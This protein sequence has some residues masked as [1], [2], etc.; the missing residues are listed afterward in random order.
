MSDEYGIPPRKPRSSRPAPR[1][2]RYD[3]GT[4]EYSFDFDFDPPPRPRPPRRRRRRRSN[5]RPLLLLLLVLVAVGAIVLGAK[6]LAGGDGGQPTAAANSSTQVVAAEP[7]ASTAAAKKSK[8]QNQPVGIPKVT[9]APMVTALPPPSYAPGATSGRNQPGLGAI[10]WV[11]LDV[12]KNEILLAHNETDKRPIASLTK[13]MTGLLTSE[14]GN[15][16]HPVTVSETAADVEPNKDGLIIGNRYP[17]GILLYSAMLGSN[18]DA[19]AALGEDLGGGNYQRYYRMM[20]KRA[21]ELGMVHTHYAS[22]SG[23]NDAANW[24]TAR[25]QA[26]LLAR[27]LGNPTF[28]Q[29]IGTWRHVVRWPDTGKR[30]TYENH[31]DMLRTYPGTIGGKTGFT[32]LAGGCL[33][34]AV[35]RN[36]RTIIGVVLH[37]QDIWADMPVL[38]DAAFKRAG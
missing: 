4:D 34:V 27:A 28:A 10:A 30:K 33:A 18:N 21:R 2:V 8:K 38:M 12:D 36:G 5:G 20:N 29:A 26:I 3:G 11:A 14:A 15:L 1:P 9:D 24:S 6:A 35:K 17:R 7:A 19:A 32:T 13:M 22:S 37:T 16:W 31:N 25:D 23:L